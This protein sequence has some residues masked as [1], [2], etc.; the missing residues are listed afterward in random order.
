VKQFDT[1][2]G[3]LTKLS[4]QLGNPPLEIGYPNLPETLF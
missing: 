2:D 3:N 1:Y 4:G